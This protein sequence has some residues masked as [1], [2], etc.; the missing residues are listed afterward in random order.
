MRFKNFKKNSVTSIYL[1]WLML[2]T[3][4]IIG[5]FMMVYLIMEFSIYNIVNVPTISDLTK[6]LYELE[7]DDFDS[8][9]I[10]RYKDTRI[11]ILDE[12]NNILVKSDNVSPR[13]SFTQSEIDKIPDFNNDDFIEVSGMKK[14]NEYYYMVIKATYKDDVK[15]VN[16]YSILDA[17]YRIVEGSLF[18]DKEYLTEREFNFLTGKFAKNYGIS[19]FTY[20]NNNGLK[21]TI[22]MVSPELSVDYYSDALT[23]VYKLWW[24]LIPCFFLI[25]LIFSLLIS[26]Q[27]KKYIAPLNEAVLG[28]TR[29]AVFDLDKYKGPYEFKEI[30]ENFNDLSQRLEE[31]E[32]KREY[33]DRERQRILTD[34]SHDLKT[35][36]TVIQGYSKAI[37]DGLVSEETKDKYIKII[38]K[39]AEA[40][41]ALTDSFFEY[42]KMEHPDFTANTEKCDICEFCKEYLA[43]K[44]QELEIS[45]FD[46]QVEIPETPIYCKIDRALF[47]RVIENIIVNAVRYNPEGTCIFFEINSETYGAAIT[48]G[49]YGIGIPESMA[50]SIFEPFTTGDM[51]R[52]SGKGTGLGMAIVKKII[53]AHHGNIRL[54]Y[55][56][57][58]GLS[59]EFKI[60]IPKAY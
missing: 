1:R 50:T 4:S 13:V 12:N 38:E 14:N 60:I 32:K 41:S 49:D 37:C 48:I 58:N 9:P 39:K 43:E 2:F 25:L 44:Y 55:P 3:I 18:G 57:E 36:I 17:N 28:V 47:R 15:F 6:Y 11:L 26:R 29:G 22:I 24:I 27:I 53:D 7:Q 20:T 21:R 23:S 34:I 51:S 19:K 35:P 8:I 52:T 56:P 46:L 31:S 54:I 5:L 33:L 10:N 16:D 30:M 40:V 59:T 42:S 45:G